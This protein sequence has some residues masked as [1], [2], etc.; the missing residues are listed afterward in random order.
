MSAE[1]GPIFSQEFSARGL[2][3]GD[4]DN[5]GAVDVLISVNDA[6]PLLLRN[7]ARKAESLAGSQLAREE[8]ESRRNWRA[9][10]LPGG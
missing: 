9:H 8:V 10:H 5:D 7:T 6:A 3:V 2:A 1:S 4:F